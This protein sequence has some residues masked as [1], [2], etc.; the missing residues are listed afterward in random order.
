MFFFQQLPILAFVLVCSIYHAIVLQSS[1]F[2]L[3][4]LYDFWTWPFLKSILHLNVNDLISFSSHFLPS[5]HASS[6]WILAFLGTLSSCM[7]KSALMPFVKNINCCATLEI[8]ML[9]VMQGI[10]FLFCYQIIAFIFTVN[11]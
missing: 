11:A 7:F 1:H 8:F 3:C 2:L 6:V 9:F 10:T 5:E 4:N